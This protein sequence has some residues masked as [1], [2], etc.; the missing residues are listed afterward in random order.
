MAD[1]PR[2]RRRSSYD[3]TPA[4]LTRGRVVLACVVLVVGLLGGY[5]ARLVFSLAHLFGESPIS[6]ITDIIHGG[7]GG[8]GSI[9]NKFANGQRVNI[10]LY[11]YGGD[12]HD[13]AY[14]TD[15]IMVVSLQPRGAGDAPR[16]SGGSHPRDW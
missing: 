14:L 15:S 11:G 6:V 1:T 13:G 4:W 16:I 9:S 3:L 7:G 10:A 5:G 12:G 8:A 2:R